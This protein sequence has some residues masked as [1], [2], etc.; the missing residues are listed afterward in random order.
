MSIGT[1]VVRQFTQRIAAGPREVFP[2]LCPV[3]ED[4][5]LEDWAQHCRLVRS[6]RGHAEPGCVFVTSH[7]DRRDTTW[8]VTRHDPET[9]VVEF[10]RVC[11]DI[12]AVTL[13]IRVRATGTGSAVEIRYTAVPLPGSEAEAFGHRWA[14]AA[15]LR[16]QRWWEASMN[17]YLTT[18]EMLRRGDR[19]AS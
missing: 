12:E 7:P 15:F 19:A 10:C 8:V 13:A 6:E 5:W 9:G 14:A 4:D 2:L 11:P 16:D 1:A 18:G 17:H 3:R